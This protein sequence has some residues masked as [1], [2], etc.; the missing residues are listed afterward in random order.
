M[1]SQRLFILYIYLLP[2]SSAYVI[3]LSKTLYMNK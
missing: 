3:I 2:S 1:L